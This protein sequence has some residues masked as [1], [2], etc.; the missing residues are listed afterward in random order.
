MLHYLAGS[1]H[2]ICKHY[3]QQLFHLS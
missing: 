3:R 1:W 2:I